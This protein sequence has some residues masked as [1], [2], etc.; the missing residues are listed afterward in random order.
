VEGPALA[1]SRQYLRPALGIVGRRAF[2]QPVLAHIQLAVVLLGALACIVQ[3]FGGLFDS[4]REVFHA[5]PIALLAL[6]PFAAKTRTDAT[7]LAVWCLAFT[8]AASWIYQH[9][10]PASRFNAFDV[11]EWAML[12]ILLRQFHRRSEV[13]AI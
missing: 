12:V 10:H 1:V 9:Q 11:L 2:N 5:A 8:F 6:L 3:L 13:A 4:S 7:T